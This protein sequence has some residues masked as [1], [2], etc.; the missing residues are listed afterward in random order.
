MD[1]AATAGIA[2]LLEEVRAATGIR[3]DLFAERVLGDEFFLLDDAPVREESYRQAGF[4]VSIR[5]R[6]STGHAAVNSLSREGF[7]LG[8]EAAA[9]RAEAGADRATVRP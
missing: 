9:A 6:G 3:I 5:Y 2:D 1:A 7:L 4:S 8:L